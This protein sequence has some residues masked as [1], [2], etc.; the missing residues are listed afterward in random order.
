MPIVETSDTTCDVTVVSVNYKVPEHL[1][2][3]IDSVERAAGH[4]SYEIV[5]VDNAS[6]DG[7]VEV[8]R[9]RFPH[10]RLIASEE[11]LGF[12]RGNNLG[13]AAARGRHLALVNPDVV[14]SPGSL[15]HLVRFLDDR[16]RAGM[17]G[18]KVLLPSGEVQSFAAELP[19]SWD[20]LVALP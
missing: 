19:S 15:E 4:L 2:H 5:V 18:P 6:G 13:A 1:G 12:A 20:V 8:L 17:V 10:V 3:M 7:S 14:L 16:P 9:G 11:N